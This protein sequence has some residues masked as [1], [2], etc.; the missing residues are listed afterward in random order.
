MRVVIREGSLGG[1]GIGRCVSHSQVVLLAGFLFIL[2]S[3]LHHLALAPSPSPA[4]EAHRWRKGTKGHNTDSP[5]N[6]GRQQPPLHHHHSPIAEASRHTPYHT[7]KQSHTQPRQIKPSDGGGEGRT[8][9]DGGDYRTWMPGGRGL[10]GCWRHTLRHPQHTPQHPPKHTPRS[11]PLP[12]LV[13]REG[14]TTTA[15]DMDGVCQPP[16][17]K[18]GLLPRG[19]NGG[20]RVRP[21]AG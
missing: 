8:T 9:E 5:T 7:Y 15:A 18:N 17:G 11:N 1:L 2:L 20:R 3:L 16:P 10:P 14:M 4:S 6:N 21:G 19:G 12:P 13:R